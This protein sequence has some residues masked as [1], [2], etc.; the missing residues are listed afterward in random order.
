LFSKQVARTRTTAAT[1]AEGEAGEGAQGVGGP[2]GDTA[3]K[4]RGGQ[5]NKTF[6]VRGAEKFWEAG[7][8]AQGEG[9]S[10]LN[11]IRSLLNGIRSLLGSGS[12]CQGE[13]ALIIFYTFYVNMSKF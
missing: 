9:R 8:H 13:G 5:K 12:A 4:G 7:A 1:S 3:A 2:V 6:G 10:L 11:G